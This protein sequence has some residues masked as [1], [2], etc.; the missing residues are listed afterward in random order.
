MA[1]CA[2]KRRE[3]ELTAGEWIE[4]ASLR[5]A[6]AGLDSPRFEAQLI[7]ARALGQSRSWVLSHLDEP[8]EESLAEPDLA[9]RLQREPLAYIFGVKEF[10]GRPFAVRP[11]VLIPRPET[12]CLIELV[13]E[14]ARDWPHLNSVL[15]V[16]TGSGCIA[17][18]LALE[19]R[20]RLTGT[21]IS[22]AAFAVA[23]QNASALG[24]EVEFLLGNKFDP[25][26]ERR[27]DM[28]VSNPPYIPEGEELMPE[29]GEHEPPEALFAGE[30]GLAAYRW[31]AE[32]SIRH[33]TEEG[34]LCVEIGAGQSETVEAIADHAGWELLR[35]MRDLSGIERV[36]AFR[37]RV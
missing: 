29:V 24:A 25:V 37:R 12:E 20:L 16:G 33:S 22:A 4:S 35:S 19:T 27:F 11:G 5:L 28:I 8:F 18:T 2:R 15:D 13:M 9:R 34:W 32:E 21:D 30:D 6:S 26:D 17:I 3:V 1:P 10:Y 36:L 7:A 14:I 23:E 31:I